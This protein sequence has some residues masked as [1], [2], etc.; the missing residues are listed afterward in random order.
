MPGTRTWIPRAIASA[1][2]P[3]RRPAGDVPIRRHFPSA[4]FGERLESAQQ[5]ID[6]ELKQTVLIVCR[7]IV[8]KL[9]ERRILFARQRLERLARL[10]EHLAAARAGHRG[11]GGKARFVGDK[12]SH[13]IVGVIG[14]TRGVLP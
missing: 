10:R 12:L 7:Q 5:E 4:A 2:W 8:G 6:A 1:T 13:E 3:P 9:Y 14:G 11:K